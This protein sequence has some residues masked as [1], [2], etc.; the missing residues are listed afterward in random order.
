MVKP[1]RL[2]ALE[3]VPG[4]GKTAVMVELA[5]RLGTGCLG[6]PELNPP[7][8]GTTRVAGS[9]DRWAWYHAAWLRR[10]PLLRSLGQFDTVLV[11]RS[12]LSTVACSYARMCALGGREY[13]AARAAAIEAFGEATWDFMVILWTEPE[14]GLARRRRAGQHVPWPWAQARFLRALS[15]FYECEIQALHR[16][17]VVHV[18]TTATELSEVVDLLEAV[19][20]DRTGLH[21]T[22]PAG[23]NCEAVDRRLLAAGAELGLG[24]P[25]GSGFLVAGYPTRYFRQHALQLRDGRVTAEFDWLPALLRDTGALRRPKADGRGCGRSA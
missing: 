25:Y 21:A 16:A 6:V 18:D 23:P 7:L 8:D 4:S 11:D 12:H 15:E 17:P 24:P 9:G 19:V 20:R 3:G 22:A 14:A 10:Q 5:R 13:P 2:V 1:R